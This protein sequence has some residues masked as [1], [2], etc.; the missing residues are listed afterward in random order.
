MRFCFHTSA[1]GLIGFLFMQAEVK[2]TNP[3]CV[4]LVAKLPS[5]A[6]NSVSGAIRTKSDIVIEQ[7][8]TKAESHIRDQL[9]A[10]NIHSQIIRQ[11][12]SSGLSA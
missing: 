7:L 1:R 11:S 8:R 10:Q 12:D 4:E 6:E 9:V 5:D 3:D 2:N